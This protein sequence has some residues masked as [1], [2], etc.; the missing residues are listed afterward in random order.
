MTRIALLLILALAAG[1]YAWVALRPVPVETMAVRTGDAAEVVFATGVVEP[2]RWAKVTTLIRGRIV[3]SCDCEGAWVDKGAI[4]FRL[5]DTE[6]RAHADELRALL[7]LA[8]KELARAADLFDRGITTRERY[9]RD[10]ANVA[11]LRASLAAAEAQ[12]VDLEIR[13]PLAGRV[14]RLEGEVGEVAALGEGLAWVGSPRPL[15]VIADVNEEDIPLV[16]VGQEALLTA[17][18][19]P[20]RDLRATVSSIT[21]MGDP[22]LKTYRVRLSLPDDTPLFIGMSVDVNI[23]AERVEDVLLVPTTALVGVR[24]QVV[25]DGRL[26]FRRIETGIEGAEWVEVRAGLALGDAVVAPARDDLAPGTRVRPEPR[27]AMVP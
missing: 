19:F 9:D 10:L 6:M 18:A 17:D 16:E 8:E 7:E 11:K 24:V 20:A 2:E 4:L 15:L 12:I 26:A 23:V 5:D 27:E 3:E 14:L 21:P 22:E 25:Q 1:G 13:A